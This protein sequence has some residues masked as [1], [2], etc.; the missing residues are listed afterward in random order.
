M[1]KLNSIEVLTPTQRISNQIEA[2]TDWRGGI[3][4]RI[5]QLVL[6]AYPG[7]I[8]EWKW[9][10]A[11]WS[12]HG[13]LCSAAAFKDHVKIHFFQ[14]AFLE[15]SRGLFNAGLDGS[16]MR[17]IDFEEGT[18]INEAGLK[19]LVRVAVSYN[20]KKMPGRP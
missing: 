12:Y 16:K 7:I 19:D 10:T 5:R 2:L 6:E 20:E 18:E 8:E 9:G 4:T 3:F 11:V 1:K 17:A 15:D 13:M 14:G